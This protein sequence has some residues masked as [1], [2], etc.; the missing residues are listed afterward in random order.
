[1]KLK[2][3]FSKKKSRLDKIEESIKD[4]EKRIFKEKD[5]GLSVLRGYYLSM[6]SN[7][8]EPITLEEE[9]MELQDKL[10][11]L[12]KTLKVKIEKSKA[13]DAEWK[14]KKVKK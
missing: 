14:A 11:A 2:E 13:K 5:A 3:I 10:D 12:S 9:I 6:F 1:M 4:L 8:Y 7:N